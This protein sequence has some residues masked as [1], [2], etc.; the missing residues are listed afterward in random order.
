MHQLCDNL[1]SFILKSW[2]KT[3]WLA[4]F[5]SA[6]WLTW[7][8]FIST[9]RPPISSTFFSIIAWNKVEKFDWIQFNKQSNRLILNL[10]LIKNRFW[11]KF[12]AWLKLD[13]LPLY[14]SFYRLDHFCL[15]I[16]CL[17]FYR[18]YFRSNVVSVTPTGRR[19]SGHCTT[20][21]IDFC[22]FSI[23]CLSKSEE[24]SRL[25]LVAAVVRALQ[26]VA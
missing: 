5:Y 10:F 12:S 1:F 18:D 14:R 9:F 8:T 21:P 17:S 23:N 22:F 19:I 7:S 6:L 16:N 20:L 3:G 26:P 4:R 13:W 24:A 11:E 15:W 2:R 25:S